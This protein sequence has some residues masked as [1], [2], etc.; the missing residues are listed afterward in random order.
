[1][2]IKESAKSN[3]HSG[4]LH[5]YALDVLEIADLHK[6]IITY[7]TH[8]RKKLFTLQPKSFVNDPGKV[9]ASSWV[10]LIALSIIWGSAFFLIELAL[11]G[12]SP[13]WLVAARMSIAAAF[14]CMLWASHGFS[15]RLGRRSDGLGLILLGLFNT[16]LPFFL[17][18]WGQQYVSSSLAGVS[19]A[20]AGLIMLPL[21]HFFA[22]SET[23][24]RRKIMGFLTGFVG[25]LLL[26]DIDN[27][28][29]SGKKDELFGGLACLL[30]AC[31][32]AISSIIM[33]RLSTVD[34]VGLSAL[35][36][37]T[38]ALLSVGFALATEGSPPSVASDTMSIIIILAIIPTAFANLMRIRIIRQSGPIFLSS[39]SYLV[40]AW[41]VVF[42]A[43]FLGEEVTYSLIMSLVL[44]L[45]G[46]AISQ[47]SDERVRF[48]G[49]IFHWRNGQQRAG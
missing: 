30:A 28:S 44:I 42:G 15:L 18:S 1:M 17:L 2:I 38:G 10:L 25:I 7:N 22:P 36:M 8:M 12:I 23:V 29:F 49:F 47:L 33:K 16:A 43:L 31:S 34:A 46:V 3:S 32:Y 24:D 6:S 40:P 9:P 19:M 4:R 20:S 14:T 27:A 35:S 13:G 26:F 39:V 45:S 48:F 5:S 37:L 11:R 41:A 21:A